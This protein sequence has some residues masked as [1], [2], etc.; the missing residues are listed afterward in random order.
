M[1]RTMAN[2]KWLI[3]R[4]GWNVFRLYGREAT[5][6]SLLLLS[7]PKSSVHPFPPLAVMDKA[8]SASLF[9]SQSGLA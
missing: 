9:R 6:A 5:L 7:S 8:L 3:S 1:R 2:H 4:R